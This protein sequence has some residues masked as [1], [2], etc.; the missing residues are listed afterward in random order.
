[1]GM[2]YK[3]EKILICICI[4]LT[5][6]LG[7]FITAGG[8]QD[9]TASSA[10]TT[11]TSIAVFVPGIVSGNPVYEMLTAG[12]KK[13]V[14][15]ATDSGKNVSTYVLEAGTNQA[16][17]GTKMT[18]LVA[19]QEYD[20]I[21]SSNP[22]LPEII[23]PISE[24]FPDQNFLIFDAYSEGNPHITTF[25]YNQREQG[26]ISGYMAALISSSSMKYA[27][28]EKKIGLIAGQEYPAMNEIILP[29]YLEGARVVD[30]AYTVDFRVVGNWYDAAKGAELARAMKN[31]GVDVI[32]PISGGANQGTIA[33]AKEVGMYVA[34][35]DDNGY[36]QAPGYVI[37]SSVMAQERLAYEQTLAFIN[38]TLK[39]GQA[40]TIG[41]KDGYID[42]VENDPA[43]IQ[44]VPADI[45]EKEAALLKQIR[46]GAL[47]LPV[48]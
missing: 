40:S 4:V 45:R 42:F 2:N 14:Q 28:P 33:A 29:A 46:S 21:I 43:Y 34:W 18:T 47:S 39:Q 27:N 36:A 16:D 32:M 41:I 5:L 17:W 37:S 35:F 31:A 15:E 9:V 25:R 48:K 13:A 23:A 3:R 6:F 19:E 38:G 44:T 26:Y 10:K 7:G 1:M 24:Q 8:K 30:P 11:K 12:V 22:S 20:V